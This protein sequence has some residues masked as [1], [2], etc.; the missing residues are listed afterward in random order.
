M[1]NLDIDIDILYYN[2]CF[3]HNILFFITLIASCIVSSDN[4]DE[5]YKSIIYWLI[6]LSIK[7]GSDRGS[8]K[9]DIIIFGLII[10]ENNKLQNFGNVNV[11]TSHKISYMFSRVAK[12][13]YAQSCFTE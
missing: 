6:T 4:N 5:K 2:T 13:E 1:S 12:K 3:K 7:L 8:F 10:R 9:F 11:I